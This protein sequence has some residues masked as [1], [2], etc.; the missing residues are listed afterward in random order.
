MKTESAWV[1]VR[2]GP[3]SEEPSI[4]HTLE[5]MGSVLLFSSKAQANRHIENFIPKGRQ[6]NFK[7]VEVE[8][9]IKEEKR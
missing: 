3:Y 4:S 9:T 5:L 2:I 6:E 7:P 8:I 1:L